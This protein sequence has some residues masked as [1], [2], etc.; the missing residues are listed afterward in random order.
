MARIGRYWDE[1]TMYKLWGSTATLL[2]DD[3][4]TRPHHLSI[5]KC[6]DRMATRQL[7][8]RGDKNGNRIGRYWDEPYKYGVNRDTF[9]RCTR[10]EVRASGYLREAGG[11]LKIMQGKSAWIF[12]RQT[13]VN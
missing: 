5:S 6:C 3:P 8:Q 11:C 12:G 4:S 2:K 10:S 7:I 1:P 9:E 13:I